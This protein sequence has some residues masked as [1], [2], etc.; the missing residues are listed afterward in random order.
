LFHDLPVSLRLNGSAQSRLQL[1]DQIMAERNLLVDVFSGDVKGKPQWDAV[2][3]APE[4]VG[5]IIK[6]TE[7][8]GFGPD[9]FKVNWAKLRDVA[10]DRYGTTWFR[11]AYHFMRFEESGADQADFYLRKIDEAGGFGP[12]DIIPIVDVELGNDGKPDE[13]GVVKPRHPNQDAS[14]Q[15]IIDFTTEW[16]NRVREVTGQQVM[17]YGNGAMRDKGITDRMGCDWLWIPRYTPTLPAQ[18]YTRAG[19]DLPSV[20]MWQY[21]GDGTAFLANYPKE[22]AGFGKVDISVVLFETL[23]DFCSK[24]CGQAAA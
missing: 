2:V 14:A 22:V 20:A 11:G 17:L 24:V 4:F 7:G 8:T 15:K 23:S 16:A 12:G 3:A 18:M 6:A 19:W 21:C 13:N 10:P 5:G 9:W 1:E